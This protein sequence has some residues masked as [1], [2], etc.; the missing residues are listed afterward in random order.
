MASQHSIRG[1]TRAAGLIGLPRDRGPFRY[2]PPKGYDP[3][4]PLPRGPNG[5]F[6]DRDDNEWVE[7]PAHGI[8][9]ADGDAREWDVQLSQRGENGWG[10][11]AK[12]IR[13][14]SYVNVTKNGRFSH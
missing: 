13:G 8:A 5:G 11:F 3:S 6:M 9:F 2:L 7:G 4:Q 14:R 12:T 1:R 10:R